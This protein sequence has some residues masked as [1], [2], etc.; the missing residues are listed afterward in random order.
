VLRPAQSH[1]TA[2]SYSPSTGS[3]M[4]HVSE[5][6]STEGSSHSRLSGLHFL[7]MPK[8]SFA[9]GFCLY[10]FRMQI[11][12]KRLAF[13]LLVQF[14]SVKAEEWFASRCIVG[15]TLPRIGFSV[16]S[17]NGTGTPPRFIPSIAVFQALH[18]ST[19]MFL[20]LSQYLEDTTFL[21][22]SFASHW[23]S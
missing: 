20:M 4:S 23:K 6:H 18:R 16:F 21:I 2:G 3:V 11:K 15:K 13:G 8:L 5:T 7:A 1:K 22:S 9:L 17:L 19:N 10:P 12:R 14:T